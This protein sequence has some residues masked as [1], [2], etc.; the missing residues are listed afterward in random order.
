MLVKGQRIS[1]IT[2]IAMF[3]GV[4]VGFGYALSFLPNVELIT[5]TIFTSGIVL[6]PVYAMLVGLLSFAIYS[7]F[8]PYGISPFPLFLTQIAGGI[9]I[10]FAGGTFGKLVV[11]VQNNLVRSVF[12]ALAGLI[13]TFIYDVL[14]N[15]GAYVSIGNP[16]VSLW[17]FIAGGLSFAF[18]HLVS[19]TLVFFF[20]SFIWNYVL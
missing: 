10:G 11:K 18:V 15:I 16:S 19:N 12:S 14:T 8:N 6:G 3:V 1:K 17:L 9:V 4:A 7:F 5:F 2:L 13:V 20:F